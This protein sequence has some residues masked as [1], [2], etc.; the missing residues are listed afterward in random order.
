M[1]D[2]ER[3]IGRPRA[4]AVGVA[5]AVAAGALVVG[6]PAGAQELP[7]TA[8]ADYVCDGAGY[9]QVSIVDEFS[10]TYNIYIDDVLVDEEVTDSDGG[11]YGYGP[12]ADGVHNVR[13]AWIS[14]QQDIL[15]LDLT[16]DCVPDETTSTTVASTTSTTAAT[17]TTVT[18]AAT[19]PARPAAAAAV[20]AAPRYTG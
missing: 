16:V 4:A 6:A 20:V 18:T 19:A 15:D 5:L 10:T 14:G 17:S 12:Y 13:V 7:P 1:R 8:S 11:T 9:I 3:E 2:L